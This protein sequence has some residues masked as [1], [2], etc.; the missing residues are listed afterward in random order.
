MC[1]RL[2]FELEVPCRPPAQVFQGVWLCLPAIPTQAA[3]GQGCTGTSVQREGIKA[4]A[5]R[6]GK[7]GEIRN[8]AARTPMVQSKSIQR[9]QEAQELPTMPPRALVAVAR[10]SKGAHMWH[11]RGKT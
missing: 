7:G 11:P 5:P 9:R 6:A 2:G 10:A 8:K 3:R 4:G 1:S